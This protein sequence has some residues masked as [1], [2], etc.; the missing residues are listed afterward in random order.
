MRLLT[1][2]LSAV[3]LLFSCTDYELDKPGNLVPKT[4]DQNPSLPSITVNGA[5]L[6]SE[7]FG[8]A[9]STMIVCIHGG[10]GADY[11]YM[12]NCKDL[13]DHGYR[14]VFYDQRGSG[15]SQRFPKASYTDLGLGAL[16]VMYDELRGV[17]AH[18]RT[19]PGQK[20]FL[21]GHSWGGMLATGYT[22]MYP[23]E[24]R[25]LVVCEPGGLKWE[26]TKKYLE[27]VFSFDIWSEW[28]NDA[29]Y[30][31]QFITGKEDEHEI[32]DYKIGIIL[33][34]METTG[35]DR[36]V[37][38]SFWRGGAVINSALSEI[39]E[40]HEPDF[41]KGI[42]NFN[43][44]VLFFYC[45]KNEAYGDAWAQKISSAYNSAELFKV[46]GV[47]HD[48]IIKDKKAWKEQTLPKILTYF[49]SLNQ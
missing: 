14:V 23:S 11:R 27:S 48:D 17:I 15:L 44:P 28:M 21:L 41:S 18:Y 38:G 20:V 40:D 1:L 24:I 39:G 33:S 12:L 45:E 43:V 36:T 25:A 47:G 35:D 46:M 32:L 9:D 8:P 7:A 29:T 42:G 2:F 16:D 19:N 26:D 3:L 49:N 34:K 10:P 4:V 31:D 30:L 6:H 37:P 22:G 5:M 13:A